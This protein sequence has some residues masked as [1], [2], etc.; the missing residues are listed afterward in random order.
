MVRS[1]TGAVARLV[2][3]LSDADSPTAALATFPFDDPDEVAKLPWPTG[4]DR[5]ATVDYLQALQRVVRL[6]PEVDGAQRLLAAG[7][8]SAFAIAQLRPEELSTVLHPSLTATREA[9]HASL[10]ASTRTIQNAERVAAQTLH[11]WANLRANAGSSFTRALRVG[12]V[13]VDDMDTLL[14]KL[15]SYAD[16]FGATTYCECEECRSIFGAAAFLV[17]LLRIAHDRIDVKNSG[18]AAGWRLFGRRPDL[19]TTLLTCENTT[20]LVPYLRI[21]NETLAALVR[22][23]LGKP[24][25]APIAPEL[26]NRTFP[27]ALPFNAPLLTI[28]QTI[29]EQHATLAGLY[30]DFGAPT[31]AV[32]RESLGLSNEQY[33]VITTPVPPTFDAPA[34]AALAALYGVTDIA[35]LKDTARF[36]KQT[37]V[38]PADLTRLLTLGLNAQELDPA[39]GLAARF[40]VN[41]GAKK[42]AGLD[43]DGQLIAEPATLH[44]MNRFLRL[45]RILGWSFEDLDWALQTIGGV[46]ALS[47]AGLPVLAWIAAAATRTGLPI[48][49]ICAW[50]G[51][52]KTSGRGNGPVSA[53][54]FDVLYNAPAVRGASG[55]YRPADADPKR[56][57]LFKDTPVTIDW[58]ATTPAALAVTSWL[59]ASLALRDADL[60]A[61]GTAVLPQGGPATVPTLSAFARHVAIAGSLSLDISDYVILIGLL[62]VAAA[63]TAAQIDALLHLADVFGRTGLS[64][65]QAAWFAT[66]TAAADADPVYAGTPADVAQL[67]T[68]LTT[69]RATVRPPA[70][71]GAPG[72]VGD[73][74]AALIAAAFAALTTAGILTARGVLVKPLGAVTLTALAPVRAALE[75]QVGTVLAAAQKQQVPVT[76]D[77]F[78]GAMIGPAFAADVLAVLVAKGIVDPK[79]TVK[80]TS[81]D[82]SGVMGTVLNAVVATLAASS[83]SRRRDLVTQI[84][85]ELGL[86]PELVASVAD[87]AARA[88]ALPAGCDDFVDAF[89]VPPL[90]T[91]TTY[92]DAMLRSLARWVVLVQPLG[93]R[94]D[95]LAL[96]AA[97]PTRFGIKADGT[98]QGIGALVEIAIL[99][100]LERT[101]GSGL[102]PFLA[103]ADPA[104]GIV[105]AAPALAALGEWPAATTATLVGAL[106]PAKPLPDQLDPDPAV[107]TT[108]LRHVARVAACFRLAGRLGIGIDVLLQLVTAAGWT[109]AANGPALDALAQTVRTALSAR[110]A[111]DAWA[112][113]EQTIVQ[114]VDE[115]TRDALLGLA[116]WLAPQQPASAKLGTLTTPRALSEYLLLDVE[117][118]GCSTISRIVQALGSVQQYLQRCRLRLEP[119]VEVVDIPGIW[120]EWI[121]N[122]R[123]WEANRRVFLYPENYLD[124]ALRPSRTLLFRALENDLNQS[125][126]SAGSVEEAYRRYLDSFSQLARLTY[127]D[128]YSRVVHDPVHGDVDTTFFFARTSTEPYTY[129]YCTREDDVI[130]T[131][132]KKIDVTITASTITPIYVFSRLFLFWVELRQTRDSTIQPSDPSKPEGQIPQSRTNDISR[133][134]IRYTFVNASG[135][136]VQ[137][138]TLLSQDVV[139]Y[140]SWRPDDNTLITD[141]TLVDALDM[142]DASWNKVYALAVPIQAVRSANVRATQTSAGSNEKIVIVYGGMVNPATPPTLP[143]EKTGSFGDDPG[144]RDF[145]VA[146][147]SAASVVARGVTEQT[148]AFYPLQ[149]SFTINVDL[150]QDALVDPNEMLLVA[151]GTA[152]G[153]LL[154]RPE[155]DINRG[156]LA[157]VG[158]DSAVHANYVGDFIPPWSTARQPT[159]MFDGRLFEAAGI[160][161]A[162]AATYLALLQ[163]YGYIDQTTGLVPPETMRTAGTAKLLKT[164]LNEASDADVA[165]VRA[166]LFG[167]LGDPVLF[168][169]IAPAAARSVTV[170][171]RPNRFVIDNGDEA[172]LLVPAGDP[173]PSLDA[174]IAAGSAPIIPSSFVGGPIGLGASQTI[175][176]QLVQNKLVDPNT[177]AAKPTTLAAVQAVVGGDNAQ[178]VFLR[179]QNAPIVQQR[180]LEGAG[181]DATAANKVYAVLQTAAIIDP[182]G[183][184]DTSLVR[185]ENAFRVVASSAD[186]T[187]KQ[188]ARVRAAL[189]NGPAPA[190]LSYSGVAAPAGVISTQQLTFNAVRLTTSAIDELSRTLFTQGIDGLLSLGSQQAPVP[191]QVPFDRLQP[192]YMIAPPIAFDG[193]QVDFDGAFSLYFWEIFFHIPWLI[194]NRLATNGLFVDAQRWLKYIFDP[195][196]TETF[197]GPTSFSDATGDIDAPSSQAIYTALKTT[198]PPNL[199]H[200]IV[201]AGGRVVPDFT[202]ATDLTFLKT[203]TGAALVLQQTREVRAMLLNARLARPS[204]HFWNFQPFRDRQLRTL[205]EILN[206]DTAIRRWNDD[207]FDPHAIA[208]LRIGA[209][210]KAI[211]M[212]Y[213][214]QL[215]GWGDS[216]FARNSWESVQQA[217]LLYLYAHDLLGPRP[218]DLGPAPAPKPANFADILQAYPNGIPQFLIELEQHVPPPTLTVKV[219]AAARPLGGPLPYFCVPENDQLIGCWDRVEDRLYKIRHCL[220]LQGNPHPPALFEPP[221][222]P[223]ALVRAAAGGNPP[224]TVAGVSLD[225]LGYRFPLLIE[226][227][228][229]LAAQVSSLGDALLS[230]LEKQDGEA[231][232]LLR[233]THA[234]ALLAMTTAVREQTIVQLGATL[235]AL[236]HAQENALARFTYFDTLVKAGWNASES[237]Y[238]SLMTASTVFKVLSG[239]AGT[240]SAIG[241]A[242]PQFGSPFAMTYGG[243][244]LGAVL[245]A[246]SAILQIGSDVTAFGALVSQ[247]V[248]EHDRRIADWTFE[249]DTAQVE[250][251]R[252]ER[253]IAAQ[254]IVVANAQRDLAIHTAQLKQQQDVMDFL[255]RKFTNT[256]LYQWMAARIAAVY[257]QSYNAALELAG[258]AQAAYQFEL[259][260]SRRFLDAQNWD[261]QR[262]GLLAGAGLTFALDQL[263]AAYLRENVRE[264]EIERTISLL[265]M[266]PKALLDLKATGT[267]DF[268]LDET[269]FDLDFPGHYA[270][271]IK[272]ISLSIPVVVGPYQNVNATLAQNANATLLKADAAGLDFLLGGATGTPPP[273]VRVGWGSGQQVAISRGVDDS[274]LFVLDFRDERYLPFEGTGAVSGWTLRIPQDT[275]RFDVA[276]LTDVLLH[277]RYTARSGGNFENTVRGRLSKQR[278][279][280][281]VYVDVGR[282][283]AAAWNAFVATPLPQSGSVPFTFTLDAAVFARPIDAKLHIVLLRLGGTP[284]PEGA[285]IVSLAVGDATPAPVAL[286]AGIGTTNDLD[287]SANGFIG[288]AWSLRFDAA[289][290]R[291][292]GIVGDDNR[293]TLTSFEL[294]ANYE[295]KLF[296]P[297]S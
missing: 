154:F 25:D 127:V 2:A 12:S 91:A 149:R 233:E 117:M 293:L 297:P 275:N 39:T 115:Q 54:P 169:A 215:I 176:Q 191:P 105:A 268:S 141:P 55:P 78:V 68:F 8:D 85:N 229:A 87:L 165:I 289:K 175:Y 224:A 50:L 33:A 47:A 210:E 177:G 223:M 84:A 198:T 162:K 17:D 261:T 90:P 70:L 192:T 83:A 252:L 284:V 75:A 255:R 166:V 179:L 199:S 235:T 21:V 209:Y 108:F 273:S 150:N 245:T 227:A 37:A 281:A 1:S 44:R 88:A 220:D 121:L 125:D 40:Y 218:I 38:A 155:V 112:A 152:S 279:K 95:A 15:P 62:G 178:Q 216:L 200:P 66:A 168:G 246:T 231:L 143:N 163:T 236:Q 86:G 182:T 14:A 251:K 230:A 159:P 27:F 49:A 188:I 136:W 35:L 164:A 249:R 64:A 20:G 71:P 114:A 205:K 131:E 208:A 137:P 181:L 92:A 28:R 266:A 111:P 260:S 94:A 24:K 151:R 226:R 145:H 174:A 79:G 171:N 46:D 195:T 254:A 158:S 201:D 124:P 167:A 267:C 32:A 257:F 6:H 93:L 18:I 30:R 240:A 80:S 277:V 5:S 180:F 109:A 238:L 219:D 7:Y 133:A 264:L 291:Q 139:F 16:L 286:A 258:A 98:P 11:L 123:I 107:D 59:G 283:F 211:V 296:S 82:L 69:L 232:A 183:R 160:T 276:A 104:A 63:P 36:A 52:L 280:R 221:L 89:F 206:D 214:G 144:V 274:G 253:E 204:S 57:P 295:A 138:Q 34:L 256:E 43:A 58:A 96:I 269:L 77:S 26:A 185:N 23:M 9:Q 3:A 288:K 140:R 113:I 187:V 42:P 250:Q 282:T 102:L 126:V 13:R 51:D 241:Y 130:W 4:A 287:L 56:Y 262:R 72:D 243:Q 271:R 272:A 74:S 197:L 212:Q 99:A 239:V 60:R 196:S 247:T 213:V 129:Y 22:Q 122:Y 290:A 118:S 29:A 10:G 142:Q 148:A 193:A 156:R 153:A 97:Q 110:Y 53:A 103:A 270:R 157:V 170:K 31:L 173:S 217:T 228:K 278:F 294:I 202:G 186:L 120:W 194:A 265:Q 190:T 259:G 76:A 244:Q 67:G 65:A 184:V 172:F 48:T 116:L 292:A 203:S 101:L 81:A 207:P 146:L 189:Q 147:Y 263:E 161:K 128:T 132:W 285:D 222:D 134:T 119:D 100:Q 237:A 73:V 234:E 242:I 61:L 19:A 41:V 106:Y 135:N 225:L 248:G 45:G